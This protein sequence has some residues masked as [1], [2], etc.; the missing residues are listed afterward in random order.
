MSADRLNSKGSIVL[1][2]ETFDTNTASGGGTTRVYTGSKAQCQA[3]K[4]VEQ[5]FGATVTKLESTGDGNYQLTAGYT[6]D[7]SQGGSSSPPVNSHELDIELEQVDV[8]NSD[9]LRS[10]FLTAFGSQAGANIGKGK[11]KNIIEKFRTFNPDTATAD[12][13]DIINTNYPAATYPA[14]NA[15]MLNAFRGIA[16]HGVTTTLQ[17]KTVY[18][19]RITAASYNQ[20]QAGF[21]G[22]KKIWTTNEVLAFE[23]V[24]SAWWFQLPDSLWAKMP[25]TVS[26]VAGQKTEIT[27]HYT[28]VYEAWGMLYEAYGA[29]TLINF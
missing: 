2:S 4:M 29:A 3:Q 6:W 23:N 19:R 5:G 25:P 13:E 22:V 27:Y 28:A 20:V 1:K 24:P 17:Q 14:Q 26:T 15:V 10:K 12:A 21:A 16:L 8:W 18:R 11:C 7:V 9:L